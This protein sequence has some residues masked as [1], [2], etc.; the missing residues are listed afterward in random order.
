MY[1]KIR[2]E[3]DGSYQSNA[4]LMTVPSWTITQT[5]GTLNAYGYGG[6][7]SST[8]EGTE[9]GGDTDAATVSLSTTNVTSSSSLSS[10]YDIRPAYIG[11]V[12]IIRVV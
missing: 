1:A 8:T 12:Y 7:G 11:V 9:I 10:S 2:T 3:Q 4:R 5:H 6:I